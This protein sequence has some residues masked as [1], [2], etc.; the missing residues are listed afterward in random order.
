MFRKNL[1]L[2][3]YYNGYCDHLCRRRDTITI[4]RESIAN[5]YIDK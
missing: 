1:H 2:S 5:L 3:R 4:L